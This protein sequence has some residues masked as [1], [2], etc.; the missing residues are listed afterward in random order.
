[1]KEKPARCIRLSTWKTYGFLLM[2]CF[3]WGCFPQLSIYNFPMQNQGE[4]VVYLQPVPQKAS[5]LR[6]ILGQ[7]DMIPDDGVNIPVD[8]LVNEINATSFLGLQKRLASG[9]LNAGMYKGIS[10]TLSKAFVLGEE[11]ESALLIPEQPVFIEHPFTVKRNGTSTLFLSLNDSGIIASDGIRFTPSFSVADSGRDIINLTGYVSNSDS[12]N[13]TVYNKKTMQVVDVLSTGRN[14]KGMVIDTLR[15]RVYVA[16]SGDDA[17]EVIDLFKGEIIGKINLDFKDEPVEL[18]LTPDGKTL[19]SVNHGSN[20]VS[21]IDAVSEFEISRLRV[22]GKPVSVAIDPAGVKAYITNS[23]SNTIFVLDIFQQA[24]S[25]ISG[26]EGTPFKGAF[27][28][29][30]DRFYVISKNSPYLTVIDTRRLHITGK[31]F[32]GMG[33]VSIKIDS[34]TDF[35]MVGKD[36]EKDIAVVDPFS[37]SRIDTIDTGGSAVFMSIDGEENSLFAVL[38][39]KKKLLKINLTSKKIIAEIDLETSPYAVVVMG[40][41]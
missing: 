6:F 18:A 9:Y 24:I 8:L 27:N 34:Q 38:S 33:S 13:I 19:V 7:M 2:L 36:V 10:I 21:I 31:I 4:V 15:A 11:G 28:Q 32:I 25:Q 22:D 17:I 29:I 26:V 16:V 30:G 37:L 5:G 12:N 35:I 3:L 40:E 41:R 14:P 20:T 1:M 39:D 23:M